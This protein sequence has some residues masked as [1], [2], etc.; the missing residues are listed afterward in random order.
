LSNILLLNICWRLGDE[1][2]LGVLQA[3]ITIAKQ[4]MPFGNHLLLK[5]QQ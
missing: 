5:K 3:F 4:A 2:S 1:K